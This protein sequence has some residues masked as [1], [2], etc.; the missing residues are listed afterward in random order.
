MRRVKIVGGMPEFVGKTGTVVGQEKDGS[1]K[2]YRVRLDEPV[3]IPGV[4]LV[5][6]DLWA[7]SFL[8]TV[9]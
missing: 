9:R 7:G 3:E 2:L 4:G 8:K 5:C 6:D 1:V